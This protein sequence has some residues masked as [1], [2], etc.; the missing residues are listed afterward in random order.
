M[1]H[2]QAIEMMLKNLDDWRNLP[3][4]QMERR[5]DLFFGL[6]IRQ[7]VAAHTGMQIQS[8]IIPEFPFKHNE[9]TRHTINFDY[10]LFSE[11]GKVMYVLELKTDANSVDDDQLNN[12]HNASEKS[13][14]EIIQGIEIVK[15]KTKDKN[16][17]AYLL[18]KL[19]SAF[20]DSPEIVLMY[21]TPT[22]SDSNRKK[23]LTVVEERHIITFARTAELLEKTGGAVECRFAEFLRKW[24]NAPAGS[25]P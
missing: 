15:S 13:L 3:K 24:E 9:T 14:L 4:Y 10:V 17:Y 12:L 25:L 8:V 21:L 16:K 1:N 7:I 6:F 2:E 19:K 18:H 22:L 11:N 20:I 23:V 5:V